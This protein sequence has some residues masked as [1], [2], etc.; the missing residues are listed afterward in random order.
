MR[1]YRFVLISFFILTS[2]SSCNSQDTLNF[3]FVELDVLLDR[4]EDEK[5][6]IFYMVYTD[7][8]PYCNNMKATTLLDPEVI[9]YLNTNY[10]FAGVNFENPEITSFKN[11]FD[12]KTFPTFLTVNENGEEIARFTGE[13]NKEKFLTE[14]KLALNPRQH[15][16]FLKAQ[17]ESDKTNGA[18]CLR[19]VV[20]LKKGR[21]RKEVNPI[22]HEYFE[23]ISDEKMINEINWRIFTNGVSD[24]ESREYKFVIANQEKFVQITSQKRVNDKFIN[25][26]V[27]LLKP[28]VGASTTENYME[29]RAIAATITSSSVDSLLFKYDL[30]HFEAKQDWENY[31]AAAKSNIEKYAWNSVNDIQKIALNVMRNSSD[32]PSLNQALAWIKHANSLEESYQ[33]LLI[34]ARVYRKLNNFSPAIELTKKAMLLN[35]NGDNTEAEKILNDLLEKQKLQ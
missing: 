24:I 28:S 14:L 23:G 20:A 4:A 16:P 18:N 21:S 8:C 34:E 35:N 11:S 19:Y 3:D 33:G 12:I 17:Y 25:S 5:K 27:E 6:P 1:F 30:E 32:V 31:K 15:L 29:L 13:V 9:S 2:F 7:W 10:I 26:V 22:A